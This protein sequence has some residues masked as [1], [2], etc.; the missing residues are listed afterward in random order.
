MYTMYRPNDPGAVTPSVE[1]QTWRAKVHVSRASSCVHDCA[2]QVAVYSTAQLRSAYGWCRTFWKPAVWLADL[3][4]PLG[5][6]CPDRP[7]S[8]F[9]AEERHPIEAL[10]CTRE[11]APHIWQMASGPTR[12][13]RS[14]PMMLG[15]CPRQGR[16]SVQIFLALCRRR[17]GP[18]R[19]VPDARKRP[20]VLI[21][22]EHTAQ[23]ETRARN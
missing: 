3:A 1:M 21:G 6:G 18:G 9:V 14:W 13:T 11:A 17:R 16:A 10:G 4:D 5:F 8:T 19:G 22:R 7:C 23:E 20:L 2:Q 15:G 12:T